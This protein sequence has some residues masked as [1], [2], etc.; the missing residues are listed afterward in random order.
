MTLANSLKISGNRRKEE[1]TMAQYCEIAGKVTNCTDNCR[2]CLEEERREEAE[3]NDE[4][5][6]E[7]HQFL[8]TF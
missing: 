8:L 6:L 7:I 2:E 4:K 5:D 1:K 3:G